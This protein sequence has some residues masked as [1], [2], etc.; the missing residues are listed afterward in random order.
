MLK[1]NSIV[2]LVWRL[3]A[4]GEPPSEG[5]PKTVAVTT[6]RA[7]RLTAGLVSPGRML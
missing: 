6:L 5:I 4:R 2:L 3:A 1:T 7:W